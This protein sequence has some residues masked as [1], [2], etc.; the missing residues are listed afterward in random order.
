MAN[1]DEIR[2]IF[3]EEFG[4]QPSSKS[5][6]LYAATQDLIRGAASQQT[7]PKIDPPLTSSH[8][9]LPTSSNATPPISSHP[10]KS[11]WDRAPASSGKRK[12]QTGHPWRLK[13]IQSKQKKVI[14]KSVNV[15]LLEAPAEDLLMDYPFDEST[16][17]LKGYVNL[18]SQDTSTEIKEKLAEVFRT[19]LSLL[20]RSD[21]DFIKRDRNQLS[22]PVTTDSWEW[23]YDSI[24]TLCGQGKLYCRLK[25]PSS[26]LVSLFADDEDDSIENQ[27]PQV[28]P[29]GK[30]KF[31]SEESD[32]V[33][34]T[35]VKNN[36]VGDGQVP[37]SSKND[38]HVQYL[39][40]LVNDLLD[41][42]KI[43]KFKTLDD[44][45]LKLRALFSS[46]KRRIKV[47]PTECLE[48]AL[49]YYK[50]G[51]FDHN[52]KLSV[53]FKGQAAVDTGG[54]TRQFYTNVF[55]QMTTGCEEI[56]PMFEGK[57]RRMLPVHNAGFL[58]SGL[59]EIVGKIMAHSIIQVGVG[60]AAMAPCIY[61]YII[62]GDISKTIDFVSIEDSSSPVINHYLKSVSIC[63]FYE[64]KLK[65]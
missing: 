56:P 39:Q 3:R 25:E 32:V 57:E 17:L 47:V 55:D 1:K 36:S 61:K 40:G 26:H 20:V 18:S 19:K 31:K 23:D 49:I 13:S 4:R 44:S 54:V 24:K 35:N 12:A 28:L 52:I 60:F 45:L 29:N 6:S 30:K 43:V 8:A 5:Q 27:L 7:K 2:Q 64:L 11:P 48:E 21:F 16:V 34:L 51:D 10:P 46:E 38:S 9:T 15:I 50:D 58:L 65:S 41:E 62:T 53:T 63:Y 22:F 42:Q 37:C 33:D 14:T 59:M